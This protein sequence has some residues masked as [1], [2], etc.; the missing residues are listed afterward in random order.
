MSSEGEEGVGNLRVHVCVR[1][2]E[3]VGEKKITSTLQSG[4]KSLKVEEGGKPTHPR[5]NRQMNK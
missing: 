1:L 3:T 4:K 5:I 2:E